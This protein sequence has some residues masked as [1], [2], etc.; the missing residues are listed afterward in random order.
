VKRLVV[1]DVS[2]RVIVPAVFLGSLWLL[3]AGHNQPGGGFEGGIVA[4]AAVALRYVAG[5]ISEVRSLSRA[6]PWTVLGAGLLIAATTSIVP[7]LFGD[8]LLE[9]AFF[10]ADLPV[11]GDVAATSALVFDVGV[12][13]VVVGLVLMV[14]ESFGDDVEPEARAR[15]S[16]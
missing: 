4:S 13:L 8:N 5:G 12:Y 1:L 14:F 16:A 3:L 6:K 2:V 7:L 9:S 11:V 15:D 10:E